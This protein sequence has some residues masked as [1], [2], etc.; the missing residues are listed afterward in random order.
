MRIFI[1]GAT[2]VLGRRVVDLLVAGGHAVA[3]FSRS[4]ANAAWLAQHGAEARAGDLFDVERVCALSAG[5]DAVLHL[6]TAIPTGTR[7]TPADWA[8]NDRIRRDGTR[9]LVEAAVRNACKLY[10][11][12]SITF[13]YGDHGDA[14]VDERTPIDA[15]PGGVLQSAV[16]MEGIVQA[17]VRAHGL[18]AVTLRCGSFY[19]HD[20]A[21]TRT[22]F[23]ALRKGIFPIIGG[24]ACYW[25]PIDVDDAARA[26]VAAVQ[27]PSAAAGLTANV[28]DDEPVLYRDLA[29]YAAQVMGARRPMGMP[30]A[31]ANL[32]LGASMVH[33]LTTSTRCRNTLARER[34]GWQPQYPTYREGYRAEI[35]KWLEE[36]KS[37]KVKGKK[38]SAIGQRA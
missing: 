18:P 19:S 24:G 20:S 30:I 22:M 15:Q 6:A 13:L 31:L 17:A 23:D 27:A 14:W 32:A 10:V 3:A 5:C 25:S 16:D 38:K 36:R 29:V 1:A 9:A 28:C 34:L 7:T 4:D 37:K 26:V 33:V 35:E 8:A 12:Q 21:Q 11:Q 2:G